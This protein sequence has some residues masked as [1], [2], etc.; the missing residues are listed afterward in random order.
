MVAVITFPFKLIFWIF[1]VLF[2]ILKFIFSP[3]GL[4]VCLLLA[5]VVVGINI[6]NTNVSHG[7]SKHGADAILAQNCFDQFGID[8][9]VRDDATNKQ[10]EYCLDEEGRIAIRIVKLISGRAEEITKFVRHDKAY[11][12]EELIAI[13]DEEYGK[14]GYIS[15][16]GERVY[17][18]IIILP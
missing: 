9:T 11:T 6:Y 16:I 4:I 15:F 13:A 17:P 3:T 2:S 1:Q 12:F 5:V 10:A 14:Y 18:Y 8:L 7:E